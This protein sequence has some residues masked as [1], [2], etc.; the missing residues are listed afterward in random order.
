MDEKIKIKFLS[1][2]IYS[3]ARK[4]RFYFH[5]KPTYHRIK[6]FIS[7]Y[8][9]GLIKRID[10]HHVFLLGGGLA[11]SLFVCIIP[12]VLIIFWVLGNFLTSGNAQIQLN[13]FIDT[14]IPYHLYADFV[15]SIMTKRIAEL[16]QF[17]NIV[18]YIGIIGLLIAASGFSSSIRT[19]LNKVFCP[20]LDVNVVMG[21]LKDFALVFIGVFIFLIASIIFP[22][23]EILRSIP[24][25][26]PSLHFFEYNTFHK[27]FTSIVSVIVIFI[28]FS[29][30]YRFI[31]IRKL[32]QKSIAIGAFW[33]TILWE[34][35][36]QIFGY[37]IYHF[38]SIS[39]I[40]GAY[41]FLVVVAFW[42][43]YSSIIFIIGAEISKLYS[44][45]VYSEN[46]PY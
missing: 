6:E 40:Y 44:D 11:F 28:L 35:A 27:I 34:T 10:E 19:I 14:I 9:G 20:D 41:T 37:Y 12:F 15:K 38:G 33:S 45:K 17:K 1:S 29:S 24:N 46:V 5:L 39:K 18:G 30:L 2:K 22:S 8:F 23:F 16:V 26:I 42:I 32:P 21:K 3:F 31:P 4:I 25:E 36:K 43:Y 13:R 7:Y